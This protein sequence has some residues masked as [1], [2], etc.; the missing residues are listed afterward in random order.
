MFISLFRMFTVI[1]L[2][3]GTVLQFF[4]FME[5]MLPLW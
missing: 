3:V 1:Q 2:V 5:K 4:H